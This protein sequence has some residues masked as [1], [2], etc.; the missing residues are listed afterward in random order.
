MNNKEFRRYII[1]KY[2]IK[3]N[4]KDE[5]AYG[6]DY[7]SPL[8]KEDENALLDILHN[9]KDGVQVAFAKDYLTYAYIST[10]YSYI[11]NRS[12]IRD[13]LLDRNELLSR[14]G[15][16]LNSCLKYYDYK[17]EDGTSLINYL[18]ASYIS[19][20]KFMHRQRISRQKRG[21]GPELS[22]DDLI[23]MEETKISL[24]EKEEWVGEDYEDFPT[25]ISHKAQTEEIEKERQQNTLNYTDKILGLLN[26]DARAFLVKRYGIEGGD[27][28]TLEQISKNDGIK[29]STI[30]GKYD[31]LKHYLTQM[32]QRAND[33]YKYYQ[34]GMSDK[35]IAE[36]ADVKEYLVDYYIDLY[37]Y[38]YEGGK[39]PKR[40]FGVV[41][42]HNSV[43]YDMQEKDL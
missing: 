40:V 6:F 7:I 38:L 19:T 41:N 2:P 3:T 29:L 15:E 43:A 4:K 32:V 26:A 39:K 30:K 14:L 20:T 22:L 23:S 11:R 10:I 13:G 5:F 42:S 8:S 25:Y 16:T 12:D 33:T 21:N 27:R 17:R 34:M 24:D 28:L 31:A 9:S 1:D 36:N 37:K 35:E 18:Y